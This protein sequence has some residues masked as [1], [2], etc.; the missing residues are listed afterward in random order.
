LPTIAAVI[1]V[2]VVTLLVI[3]IGIGILLVIFV[4]TWR[5]KQE[6][7]IEKFQSIMIDNEN[8]E[9]TLVK[10]RQEENNQVVNPHYHPYTGENILET[11]LE[12]DI[13]LEHEDDQPKSVSGE[14]DSPKLHNRD[15][16]HSPEVKEGT[17]PGYSEKLDT[18]QPLYSAVQ[19]TK[20]PIPQKSSELYADLKAEKEAN[21]DLPVYA[22]V[23]KEAPPTV[24]S[25]SE[26]LTE[27]LESQNQSSNLTGEYGT[28]SSLTSPRKRSG[29][30]C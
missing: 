5:K 30:E 25:K 9:L 20:A 23:V 15:V 28:L 21:A 8:I 18:I 24:P 7:E 1:I 17:P 29:I 6:S 14:A 27:Y 13:P 22:A 12:K 10:L 3:V 4:R 16:R 11:K 19:K 26:E 2:G